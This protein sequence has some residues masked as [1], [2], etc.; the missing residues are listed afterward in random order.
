MGTSEKSSLIFIAYG[1]KGVEPVH[2]K[3]TKQPEGGY[4][5][6][7]NQSRTGTLVNG[8]PVT[9]P[10]AL[11]DGDTIQFGVNVVRFNEQVK[12]GHA[13]QNLPDAKAKPHV[14]AIPAGAIQAN[15]PTAKPA[16]PSAIQSAPSPAIQTAKPAPT[17]PK[18]AATAAKP[19]EARCPICDKKIVGV[20]GERRCTQCFTTF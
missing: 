4:L 16:T 17:A 9:A 12:H 2:L 13:A 8:K 11:V 5:L 20:P 7:D 19:Q 15:V 14:S 10:T 1:A 6:E 3:I 18:P